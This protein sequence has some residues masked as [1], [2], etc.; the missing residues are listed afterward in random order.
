MVVITAVKIAN[1]DWSHVTEIEKKAADAK[2]KKY[3]VDKSGDP[4][5]SLMNMMRKM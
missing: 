4:N 1:S 3:E 5:D 2:A